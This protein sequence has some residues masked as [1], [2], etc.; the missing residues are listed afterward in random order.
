MLAP[1]NDPQT[2]ACFDAERAVVAALGGGCQLPLGVV[3]VHTEGHLEMHAVVASPDGAR[4]IRESVI[5]DPR[6]PAELGSALASVLA[7][8]GAIA[9][10]DEVRY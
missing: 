7:A 8:A 10:L 1:I 3:A 6:R 5:G 9:I 2:A 4:Q